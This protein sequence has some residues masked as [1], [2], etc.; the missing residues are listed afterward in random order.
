[1]RCP[2]C[3]DLMV[4]D[5]AGWDS[6]AQ[7]YIVGFK[8]RRC[9]YIEFHGIVWVLMNYTWQEIARMGSDGHK[10]VER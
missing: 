1:M 8:C 2:L 4:P 9:G 6:M 5:I 10:D 3:R 7:A